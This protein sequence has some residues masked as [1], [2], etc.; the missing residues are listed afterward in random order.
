[1]SYYEY[2]HRVGFEETNVVGNVYFT[3]YLRWQGRCREMF[4]H[5]HAP[6]LMPELGRGLVLATTRVA[7]SYYRELAP[8][9]EV[10]VRMGAAAM[11]LSRLT[12]TFQYFRLGPGGEEELVAEGEQEVACMH[13]ANDRMEPAA[14]PQALR[15]AVEL[16][17]R[18]QAVS[19][20]DFAVTL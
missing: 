5:Q 17:M 15:D 6:E 18:P 2:R 1:M 4:L 9:D 14:L 7:C 20:A 19:S 8:L 10:A 11:T 16:Y 3:H 13:R 12:I